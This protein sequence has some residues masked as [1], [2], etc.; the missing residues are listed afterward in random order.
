MENCTF[1]GQHI[2]I[3]VLFVSQLQKVAE[4]CAIFF[5]YCC[6]VGELL[7][8]S[9]VLQ[10]EAECVATLVPVVKA[11]VTTQSRQQPHGCVGIFSIKQV[12]SVG[13]TVLQKKKEKRHSFIFIYLLLRATWPHVVTSFLLLFFSPHNDRRTIHGILQFLL[14]CAQIPRDVVALL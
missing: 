4:L 11:V 12:G 10:K 9:H 7:R 6:Q 13:R 14:K 1:I 8:A 2:W 3:A 5:Q